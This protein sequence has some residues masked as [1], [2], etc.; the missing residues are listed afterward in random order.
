MSGPGPSDR[1]GGPGG[2]GR[3]GSDG[4]DDGDDGSRSPERG[5]GLLAAL[6]RLTDALVD[7]ET[8]GGRR[9]VVQEDDRRFEYRLGVSTVEDLLDERGATP[10]AEEGRY[11]RLDPPTSVYEGPEGVVVHVD[12]PEVEG[13]TVA[14]AVDGGT[15]FVGVGKTII[16]EVDLPRSGLEVQHGEYTNGVLEFF[17]REPD[18]DPTGG[19]GGGE[20]R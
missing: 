1:P 10:E 4:G 7:L 3:H 19:D 9:R 14:A 11:A 13:E 12:L 20:R 2:P 17:L 6:R 15:L 8:S 16:A 5:R 18:T